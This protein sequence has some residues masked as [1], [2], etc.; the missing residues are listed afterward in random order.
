MLQGDYYVLWSLSASTDNHEDYWEGLGLSAVELHT[1]ACHHVPVTAR[2]HLDRATPAHRHFSAGEGP[3]TRESKDTSINP[4]DWARDRATFSPVHLLQ[5]NS[6]CCVSCLD[7]PI[8]Q[9]NFGD[10]ITTVNTLE[11]AHGLR[12]SFKEP[13]KNS[14]MP[15]GK[16]YW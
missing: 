16:K 15:W 11:V 14:H 5:G 4:G 13:H 3:A 8:K 9:M 12:E 7:D 10:A 2:Q 1:S 6:W